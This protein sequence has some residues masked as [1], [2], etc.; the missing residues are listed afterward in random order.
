[1]SESTNL[2][3]QEVE[4]DASDGFPTKECPECQANPNPPEAATPE[5]TTG[6]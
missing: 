6:E 2:E 3:E 1:M 4:M 5:E